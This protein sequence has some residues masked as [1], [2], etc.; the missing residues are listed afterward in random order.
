MPGLKPLTQQEIW[1]IQD[2]KEAEEERKRKKREEAWTRMSEEEKSQARTAHI[3]R[4]GG[5]GAKA[6]IEAENKYLEKALLKEK[7]GK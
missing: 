7:Q 5:R 1:E 6:V 3:I 2:R 4:T